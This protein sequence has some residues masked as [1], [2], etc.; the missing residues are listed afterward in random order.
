MGKSRLEAKWVK[1]QLQK[2][3][4]FPDE[5]ITLLAVSSNAIV[6]YK[7]Q[8]KIIPEKIVIY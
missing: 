5:I 6:T 1:F 4:R 3:C 8:S 7:S 2:K